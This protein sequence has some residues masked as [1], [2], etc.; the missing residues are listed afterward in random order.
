MKRKYAIVLHPAENRPIRIMAVSRLGYPNTLK[1][2]I[3]RYAHKMRPLA[4]EDKSRQE[5]EISVRAR[6]CNNVAGQTNAPEGS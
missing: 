5:W 6:G 4:I 1:R 2:S 3:E